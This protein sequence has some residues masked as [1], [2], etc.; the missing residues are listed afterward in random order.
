MEDRRKIILNSPIKFS[1]FVN[2]D[3]TTV[4]KATMNVEELWRATLFP[5]GE[6]E[7]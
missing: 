2:A 6:R 5:F 1:D 7:S 3:N 4:T